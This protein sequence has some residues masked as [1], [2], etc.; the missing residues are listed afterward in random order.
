MLSTTYALF[1]RRELPARQTWVLTLASCLPAGIAALVRAFGGGAEFLEATGAPLTLFGP[2]VLVPIFYAV[3]AF[4]EEF[5]SRTIVYLLTRP[6]SRTIY[7]AGK[8]LTAW[9]CS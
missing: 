3:A 9:T 8:L 2:A 1:L 6:P 7:V 4:H 5:E